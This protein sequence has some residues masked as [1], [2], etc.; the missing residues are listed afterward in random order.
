MTKPRDCTSEPCALEPAGEQLST[1][2][3]ESVAYVTRFLAGLP[4]APL[5]YAEDP[6]GVLE[7]LCAP[8]A[9]EPGDFTDVL[10]LYARAVESGIETSG[11]RMI[12]YVPGGGI[13][14]A[15][16]AEFLAAATNRYTAFSGY[17]PASVAL[18]SGVLRWICRLLGLPETALGVTTSGTSM[19]ALSALVAARDNRLG[20]V[21]DRGFGPRLA[22]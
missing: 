14:S 12:A 20:R 16:V 19:A 13:V 2:A 7:A 6:T 5:A 15:A 17:A 4:Q 9:E 18:E 10:A 11:P 8:P 1:W 21:L 22:L 3:A